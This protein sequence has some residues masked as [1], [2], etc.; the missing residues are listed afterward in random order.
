MSE[1]IY[2]IDLT[3]IPDP[4]W[5]GPHDNVEYIIDD[6]IR[7]GALKPVVPCEH[8]NTGRHIIEGTVRLVGIAEPIVEYDWCRAAVVNAGINLDATMIPAVGEETP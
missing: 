8:G 6:L 4:F 3:A 7:G 5:S 2:R 1:P